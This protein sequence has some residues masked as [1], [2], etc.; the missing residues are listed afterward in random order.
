MFS[1]VDNDMQSKGLWNMTFGYSDLLLNILCQVKTSESLLYLKWLH[2]FSV[3]HINNKVWH[4]CVSLRNVDCIS[5]LFYYRISSVDSKE[6]DPSVLVNGHF[7]SP[8]GS[9][10]AGDCGSCV[11]E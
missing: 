1:L 7:D 8:L 4:I 9:P 10:G 11:G 6:T 3:H 2:I 5:F